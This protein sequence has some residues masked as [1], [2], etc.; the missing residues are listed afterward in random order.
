MPGGAALTR[1]NVAGDA[2]L[3]A[4]HLDAQ[5]LARRVAAVPGRSACFLVSHRTVPNSLSV[6]RDSVTESS[7]KY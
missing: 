4:E 7:H 3:V 6:Y 1:D 2:L 5:A